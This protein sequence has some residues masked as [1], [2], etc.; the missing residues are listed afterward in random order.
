MD[1]I[2]TLLIPGVKVAIVFLSL[3]LSVP[4]L[5]L[6]E[7]K[8]IGRIQ[9][10]PGPNRVGLKAVVNTILRR[11]NPAGKAAH[12]N[13]GGELQ[14]ITDGIKLILKEDFIP[15]K[16]ERGIFILA[17]VLVAIPAFLTFCIVPFGPVVEFEFAGKVREISLSVTDLESGILFYLAISSIGVYGIVLAGWASNS[18]YALLGSIR[19]T[20]QLISYEITLGLS[21]IGVLLIVG[22]F[23]M[24]EIIA[25]QD[26]GFWNWIVLRQPMACLMFLVAGFA[27]TNRLPFDLPEGE[28]ELGAGYHTEYSSMKWAVFMMGEYVNIVTFSG[29]MTTLFLGGFHGPIPLA[30][31]ASPI[32]VALSGLFWFSVK[33]LAIFFFFVWVRGTLPRLR[34]DQLMNLGWKYM[35]PL[36]VMNVV[37]TAF[38]LAFIPEKATG[39]S[40]FFA[41]MVL[42]IGADVFANA[43]KRR[44]LAHVA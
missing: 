14:T 32:F 17:P 25:A 12:G 28:T 2:D 24:R 5:V 43:A 39:V 21:L 44:T 29:V 23:N 20:A 15:E 36:A 38:I 31:S 9:Q 37:A 22:S 40:L 18:K 19:A 13:W 8:F 16:A 11:E 30:L 4:V 26:G 27:E 10:R 41:G 6:I 42:L 35:F 3:V 1:W 34:Y 33:V 7:R